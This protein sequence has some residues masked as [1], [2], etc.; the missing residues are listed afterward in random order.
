MAKDFELD[1]TGAVKINDR[2]DASVIEGKKEFEQRLKLYL[3]QYHF[4]VIGETKNREN[5]IEKLRLQS[6]RVVQDFDLI[7]RMVNFE[8]TFIGPRSIDVTV[9]YEVD[10]GEL[11]SAGISLRPDPETKEIS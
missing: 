5:K 9:D 4:N 1:K 8:A 2:G 6:N 10:S 7:A 3:Q 11:A